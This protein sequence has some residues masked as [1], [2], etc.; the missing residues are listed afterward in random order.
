MLNK[1]LQT[2]SNFLRKE[3]VSVI[4][5]VSLGVVLT[6]SS[7]SDNNLSSNTVTAQAVNAE[8]L[9]DDDVQTSL[10]QNMIPSYS[11]IAK[12][13][14]EHVTINVK[15]QVVV[16][17]GYDV[18]A[19]SAENIQ[20]DYTAYV[21]EQKRK[22]EEE[23]RL[24]EEA[25][26]KRQEELASKQRTAT[27]KTTG[28]C[29]CSK[30]CGQWSPEVTGRAASTASGTTPTA[31]RTVAVDPDVIPLGSTVIIDGVSYIAEDTGSAV[32]GNV[33][34]IYFNSHSEACNWGVRYKE[35]TYI[36]Q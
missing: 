33:I 24:A 9:A 31:G 7:T 10:S 11:F 1:N 35:V 23:R 2:L 4:I 25:E 12:T 22:E 26:R 16:S 17:Q 14:S 13:E 19:T 30:C 28:Y 5:G 34:D 36:I 15:E 32:D 27:F 6:L 29:H 21:E 20:S 8:V 18:L 3:K